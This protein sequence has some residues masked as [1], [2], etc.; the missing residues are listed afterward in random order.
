MHS[1]VRG[2]RPSYDTPTAAN[3]SCIHPAPTPKSNRPLDRWSTVANWRASFKGWR[4]GEI[5]TLVPSLR[6]LVTHCHCTQFYHS[7]RRA[8]CDAIRKRA[9]PKYSPH[10]HWLI[11]AACIHDQETTANGI[12]PARLRGSPETFMRQQHNEI[13]AG[14]T[15]QVCAASSE[16][17]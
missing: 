9:D 1:S 15:E 10:A 7:Q 16:C 13:H 11:G 14:Q 3:S 4:Y 8:W 17:C 12:Q 2:P 5:N 6:R